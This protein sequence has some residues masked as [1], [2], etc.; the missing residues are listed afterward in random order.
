VAALIPHAH[1]HPSPARVPR[2][3]AGPY[4]RCFVAVGATG[5]VPTGPGAR[6]TGRGQRVSRPRPPCRGAGAGA[7]GCRPSAAHGYERS[8]HRAPEAPAAAGTVTRRDHSDLDRGRSA[9][10]RR[11][12]EL[13]RRPAGPAAR[14]YRRSARRAR[15]PAA[16]PGLGHP[17]ARDLRGPRPGRV[18]G[19]VP[20]R[21]R[22]PAG[23][24]P[25]TSW[26]PPYDGF[27]WPGASTTTR[28]GRPAPYDGTARCAGSAWRATR[29]SRSPSRWTTSPRRRWRTVRAPD[30][31][32]EPAAAAHANPVRSTGP[33]LALVTQWPPTVLSFL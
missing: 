26:P 8:C 19:A 28:C 31:Q 3:S 5:W 32:T 9:P 27:R 13:D 33:G 7:P 10:H 11:L 18:D 17:G 1:N 22:R 16:A 30:G 6:H 29:R 20:G 21:P 15:R 23:R 4:V 2:P 14:P 12:P 24:T 25:R